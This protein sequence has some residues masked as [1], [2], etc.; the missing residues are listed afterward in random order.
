MTVDT[1]EED[2][3][4]DFEDD[5]SDGY[6]CPSCAFSRKIY[7]EVDSARHDFEH[8]WKNEL[9]KKRVLGKKFW[10]QR[11]ELKLAES[12]LQEWINFLERGREWDD[13]DE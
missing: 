1:F 8:R 4:F 9:R 13:L 7:R 11:A 6:L 2:D 3:D 10:A 5:D 12:M